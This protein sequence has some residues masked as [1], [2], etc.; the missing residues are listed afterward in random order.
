L[1]INEDFGQKYTIVQYVDDTLVIMRVDINELQQP[2]EILIDFSNS[3][4]LQVN[5][6]KTSLVLPINVEEEQAKN[7]RQIFWLQN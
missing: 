6:H 3:T 4:G 2:N 5:Y 7:H 1:Q